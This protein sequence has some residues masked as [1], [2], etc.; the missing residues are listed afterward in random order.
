MGASG[1]VERPSVE[2]TLR[3]YPMA[4][5]INIAGHIFGGWIMGQLDIAGGIVALRRAKGRV[6]TVASRIEFLSPVHFG[7][8]V[9][10]YASMTRAG[11]TSITVSIEAFAE[12]KAGIHGEA[13]HAASAEL[14]Y[15]ALDEDGGKRE[16]PPED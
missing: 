11:K 7:D 14:V 1:S 5:D 15:V 9:S 8:L 6:A 13:V 16:L 3:V 12:R 2:P 4:G 10:I